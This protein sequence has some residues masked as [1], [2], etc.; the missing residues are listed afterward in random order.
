M[1]SVRLPCCMKPLKICLVVVV[2]VA[3][4]VAAEKVVPQYWLRRA[5][6]LDLG[7]IL[8]WSGSY[9]Q[10]FPQAIESTKRIL[11]N[12][13][14]GD[15][16]A[17]YA[18]GP[19]VNELSRGVVSPERVAV[20]R[21]QLDSLRP[22]ERG[23]TALGDALSRVGSALADFRGQPS[24]TR[25]HRRIVAIFSDCIGEPSQELQSS[26]P[27][28]ASV[29]VVGFR[30]AKRDAVTMA[31]LGDG[32]NDVHIVAPEE[33]SQ[34]VDSLLNAIREQAHPVKWLAAV[35]GFI[36]CLAFGTFCVVGASRVVSRQ[37][38]LLNIRLQ[39]PPDPESAQHFALAGDRTAITVGG[40]DEL[41]DFVVPVNASCAL[42]RAG[43]NLMLSPVTGEIGIQHNGERSQITKASVIEIGDSIL[44]QDFEV[45]IQR[46]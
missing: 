35:V 7:I 46:A 27:G 18:A 38:P 42:R 12:V 36:V 25:T 19:E 30:G 4:A 20:L 8:D 44:L 10:Q 39:H 3:F 24:P 16:L 11:R 5:G 23:G 6:I 2:S 33:A 34:A 41:Y 37:P 15:R 32:S 14:P 9:R 26:L 28:S 17:V 29:L 1:N 22:S 40:S 31:L 13:L 43:D 45:A 21:R